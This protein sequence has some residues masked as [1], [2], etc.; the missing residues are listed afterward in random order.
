MGRRYTDNELLALTRNRRESKALRCRIE[1]LDEE[2]ALYQDICGKE[3]SKMADLRKVNRRSSGHSPFLDNDPTT[4]S[5]PVDQSLMRK[6]SKPWAFCPAETTHNVVF[7]EV[8]AVRSVSSISA[9]R[10]KSEINRKRRSIVTARPAVNGSKESVNREMSQ[11]SKDTQNCA[12]SKDNSTCLHDDNLETGV[13]NGTVL[14]CDIRTVES[15]ISTRNDTDINGDSD[16]HIRTNASSSETVKLLDTASD[17]QS[18]ESMDKSFNNSTLDAANATQG[19]RENQQTIVQAPTTGKKRKVKKKRSSNAFVAELPSFLE[20]PDMENIPLNDTTVPSSGDLEQ[21]SIVSGTV[22]NVNCF[23]DERNSAHQTATSMNAIEHHSIPTTEQEI[24]T[25]TAGICV[26]TEEDKYAENNGK[27]IPENTEVRPKTSV[28]TERQTSHVSASGSSPSLESRPFTVAGGEVLDFESLYDTE[29]ETNVIYYKGQRLRN[30]VS[31]Q[32]RYKHDPF[33]FKRREKL[34]TKVAK[35]NPDVVEDV[36]RDS[37]K[38]ELRLS[39]S[40]RMRILDELVKENSQREINRG[41]TEDN[42]NMAD[43]IQTFLGTISYLCN[44]T[45]ERSKQMHPLLA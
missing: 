10:R 19:L 37:V 13:S 24:T 26:E 22:Y 15:M 30:Y 3:K 5:Q 9:S 20:N 4:R 45:D 17:K 40:A 18:K 43:R 35:D 11:S 14:N 36:R 38:V 34:F 28:S 32:R 39:K 41:L 33:L 7:R 29:N 27:S 8:S 44:E 23:T 25:N 31:P 1:K 42:G 12:V 16:E 6:F 21:I 2:R